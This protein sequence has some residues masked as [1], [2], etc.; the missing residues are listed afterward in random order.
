MR[1]AQW[2]RKSAPGGAAVETIST[3]N[4]RAR[5]ATTDP[6]TV[7]AAAPAIG[8][9]GTVLRPDSIIS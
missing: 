7:G 6:E 2:E 4:V 8:G 3:G 5:A 9:R 1:S